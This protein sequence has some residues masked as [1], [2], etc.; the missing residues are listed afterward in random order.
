M[1]VF[2]SPG[3]VWLNNTPL[4]RDHMTRDAGPCLLGRGRIMESGEIIL[5]T[6]A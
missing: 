1:Y 6:Q 4:S 3:K 5:L 2:S